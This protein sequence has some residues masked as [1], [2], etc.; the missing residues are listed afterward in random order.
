MAH[1]AINKKQSEQLASI[2]S[3]V[4]LLFTGVTI[5]PF[6]GTHVDSLNTTLLLLG[7]VS[8][9]MCFSVSVYLL[10]NYEF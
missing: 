4:G 2:F 9:M 3:N 5:T 6:F 8:A 7:G 10:K 1:I